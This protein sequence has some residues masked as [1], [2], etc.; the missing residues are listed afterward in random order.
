MSNEFRLEFTWSDSRPAQYGDILTYI[1]RCLLPRAGSNNED[2]VVQIEI[3]MY[4]AKKKLDMNEC[5]VYKL[6]V[7]EDSK[8]G[9]VLFLP[10]KFNS[11]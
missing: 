11:I 1:S 4:I 9:S 7:N 3:F 10:P 8:M 2:N 5:N 6:R